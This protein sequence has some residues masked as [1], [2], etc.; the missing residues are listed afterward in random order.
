MKKQIFTFFFLLNFLTYSQPTVRIVD[1]IKPLNLNY[2]SSG[3]LLLKADNVRNCVI[4]INTLSSTISIIDGFTDE[5][6]NIPTGIRGYQHLKNEA[7]VINEKNGNVYYIGDKSVAIIGV[8]SKS[9][10]K[11]IT[12]VQFESIAIDD[13]TG[14]A[15]LCGREDSRLLLI[16][17]EKD[18]IRYIDWVWHK[19]KLINL[20]QTPPPP[21]RKVIFDKKSNRVIAID[22]FESKLY[23]IDHVRGK[24]ENARNLPLTSGARWHLA[25]YNTDSQHLYL[26]VEKADRKV[27]EA[28]KID[29][30]GKNDKI[31]H[32]PEY[33]EGV[34]MIYDSVRDRIYI[35]Y[36]NHPF[37]HIVDFKQNGQVREIA[38]PSFGNNASALDEDKGLLF[39]GSWNM[40][41]IFLIDVKEEKFIRKIDNLGIIPHMFA[42][43]YLNQKGNLYFPVG[44]TAVNGTFG[45]AIKKLNPFFNFERKIYLG[46]SPVD[47]IEIKSR[48][49]FLIFNNED[50]FAEVTS[51]GDLH[52]YKL[53]YDFPIVCEYG[54][55]SSIYLSYGAHQS[56]WPTVYI[57]GAKNG[58][59]K[60]PIKI[61]SVASKGRIMVAKQQSG[62]YNI[63]SY[64][65][66]RIP[67]QAMKIVS[68][69]SGTLYFTQNCWGREPQFLGLLKDG[70]RYF[71]VGERI[72]TGDTIERENTQRVLKY[73]DETNYIYLGRV[74]EF[75]TSKSVLHIISAETK[76]IVKRL[77]VGEGITDLEYD[78]SNIYTAN[79]LANSVSTINK[80]N[81]DVQEQKT[82]NGPI[83]I[84]IHYKN[85]F[86]LNHN[87]NS[88]QQIKPI[89]YVKKIPFDG[90][91]NNLISWNNV[92]IIS[93]HS[94]DKFRLISYN[95]DKG[96]FNVIFENPYP[97]GDTRFSTINNSFYLT[98]Q[99][100]DAIYEIVKMK[101]A[102]DNSL[103]VTDFLA[104]KLYILKQ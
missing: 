84:C 82:E 72:L 22:G 55:D 27:I 70:V 99:F 42:F 39:I 74:G 13:N 66:R 32:L 54:P 90:L 19:E 45:S 73:D 47:L 58:I 3:A 35:P 56:Y 75:D 20:N 11:F 64:Y 77:E 93:Q 50:E 91:A 83:K 14:I 33:T 89:S 36:D 81:F 87:S 59:L 97:Y 86:I 60:I 10:K 101:I 8:S 34:S 6:L 78:S 5:V 18:E 1:F 63:D 103:W 85:V 25:G 65:D 62:N 92:I 52:Y 29:V 68:D 38:I 51:N 21:I 95:P 100:G 37:I 79:F 16:N 49:S 41:E 104:G 15:V 28:A 76:Q 61:N 23:I 44:A 30:F 7:V 48:N 80:K 69:K 12:E 53:P 71:D 67:R 24:I 31:V 9:T 26:V 57:W 4:S 96:T 17:P 43:A 88:I 46:W 98:G 2:N 40:G 94:E 102:S